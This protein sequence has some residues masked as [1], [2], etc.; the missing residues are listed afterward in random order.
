MTFP[1]APDAILSIPIVFPRSTPRRDQQD[2]GPIRRERG[3]TRKEA[4]LSSVYFSIT[5][6]GGRPLTAPKT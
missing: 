4:A 3:A 1:G 6:A 2:C 5:D